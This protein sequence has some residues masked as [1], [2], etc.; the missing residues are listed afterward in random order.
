M[1]FVTQHATSYMWVIPTELLT[2]WVSKLLLI[3]FVQIY[4][5][6]YKTNVF[7]ILCCLELPF[8]HLNGRIRPCSEEGP[9]WIPTVVAE[10]VEPL[11]S[12]FMY[13]CVVVTISSLYTIFF[14]FLCHHPSSGFKLFNAWTI[15]IVC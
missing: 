5:R 3:I 8:A 12:I 9:N 1:F 6:L 4:I 13:R 7:W 15:T 11:H 14:H 10:V 2:R